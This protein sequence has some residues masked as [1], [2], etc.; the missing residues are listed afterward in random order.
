M[1]L[2]RFYI[3]FF[4]LSAGVLYFMK[5][6]VID[7]KKLDEIPQLEFYSF[8]AFEMKKKQ[9]HIMLVGEETKRFDKYFLVNNFTLYEESNSTIQMVSALKGKYEDD[10]ISLEKEVQYSGK[11]DL[12]V[13]AEKALYNLK[14]QTLDVRSAF[15]MI[16]GGHSAEGDSLFFNQIN[17]TMTA[18]GIK[19]SIDL[20]SAE[21]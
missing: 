6:N 18:T 8:A 13:Y 14:F 1:S 17:G 5:P 9:L 21:K 2:T 19:A 16:Q 10:L 12:F 11:D 3:L 15:R 4:L 7:I 20:E